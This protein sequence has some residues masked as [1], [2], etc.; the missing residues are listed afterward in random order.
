MDGCECVFVCLCVC[1]LG[2]GGGGAGA[3]CFVS[4]CLRLCARARSG[5]AAVLPSLT[6]IH[7]GYATSTSISIF[8]SPGAGS[9]AT[10]AFLL[11]LLLLLAPLSSPACCALSPF[12]SAGKEGRRRKEGGEHRADGWME[13][14]MMSNNPRIESNRPVGISQPNYQAYAWPGLESIDGRGIRQPN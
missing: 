11:L 13:G 6:S 12:P 7:Q 8:I 5:C 2:G 10:R 1:V 3:E 9:G 14:W 4:A